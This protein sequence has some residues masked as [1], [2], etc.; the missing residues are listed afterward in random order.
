MTNANNHLPLLVYDGACNFCYY[1]IARWQ[2]L[3][4]ER[5]AYAPFQQ[6]ASRF[7][8]ISLEQFE[9]AVQL[10]EPSGQ[11][12]SG[13]EA[14]FRTLAY[15][16]RQQWPLWLYRKP[17]ALPLSRSGVIALSHEIVPFFLR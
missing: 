15:A 3:T 6:V 16:P 13:A 10:I 5:V 17:P 1:W 7:P 11:M 4:G 12:S 14:V 8:E 9:T 2:H